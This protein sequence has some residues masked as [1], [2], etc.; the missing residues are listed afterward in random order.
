MLP[1]SRTPPTAIGN[2]KKSGEAKP[3]A[4]QRMGSSR[5]G[6]SF[7]PQASS[8]T[9]MVNLERSEGRSFCETCK[10]GNRLG[11]VPGR[12]SDTPTIVAAG[13]RQR[14][15]FPAQQS[16]TPPAMSGGHHANRIDKNPAA[17]VAMQSWTSDA[18]VATFSPA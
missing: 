16:K 1:P 4:N 2:L 14:G 13:S 5:E 11:A 3:E 9:C 8:I 17:P 12:N 6:R 18:R 15:T 10:A 7:V